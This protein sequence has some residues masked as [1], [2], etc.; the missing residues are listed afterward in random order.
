MASRTA[1][2]TLLL[3]VVLCLALIVLKMYNVHPVT[4]AGGGADAPPT[5]AVILGCY[6]EADSECTLARSLRPIR[7][8]NDGTLITWSS[9]R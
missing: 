5:R 8:A 1:T 2:N 9:E 3:L 7:V 4:E 6:R